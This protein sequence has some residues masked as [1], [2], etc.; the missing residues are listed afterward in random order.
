ML[1]TVILYVPPM[2]AI[3]TYELHYYESHLS[4]ISF[5]A[6]QSFIWLMNN[7]PPS[8]YSSMEQTCWIV[9]ILLS[10]FSKGVLNNVCF[11]RIALAFVTNCRCHPPWCSNGRSKIKSTIFYSL[12]TVYWQQTADSTMLR[13]SSIVPPV[14]L[15]VPSCMMHAVLLAS[16]GGLV[17]STRTTA[18][19]SKYKLLWSLASSLVYNR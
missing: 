10:F 18:G 5:F 15:R 8:D 6:G 13:F 17:Y 7:V 2:S 1:S 16:A 12:F 9:V 14:L 19:F 3:G 4:S 11:W